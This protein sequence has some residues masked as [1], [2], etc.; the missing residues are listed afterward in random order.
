M[1][2]STLLYSN[3]SKI[4]VTYICM[5]KICVNLF[6][7]LFRDPCMMSP[8]QNITSLTN[9]FFLIFVNNG[10]YLTNVMSPGLS[11]PDSP[12]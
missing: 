10:E 12:R 4:C 2:R 9:A 7:S 3:S 11:S 8:N 5:C 6:M 1:D